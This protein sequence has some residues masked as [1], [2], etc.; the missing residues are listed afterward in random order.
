MNFELAVKA[1]KPEN[2]K[3]L[4]DQLYELRAI[5]SFAMGCNWSPPKS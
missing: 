3:T 4:C 1:A 5:T 2:L